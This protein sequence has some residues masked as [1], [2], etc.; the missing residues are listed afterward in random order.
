MTERE[1]WFADREG[2]LRA[3][4]Q[5]LKPPTDEFGR[6][7]PE[8]IEREQRRRDR[9]ARRKKGGGK[10]ARGASDGSRGG[11]RGLFGR[12][13]RKDAPPEPRPEDRPPP[14]ETRRAPRPRQRARSTTAEQAQT[15]PPETSERSARATARERA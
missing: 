11:L 8:S 14:T 12:R 9:E 13:G 5:R 4:D 6:D 2:N 15:A 7:D 3:P 1:D 10:P